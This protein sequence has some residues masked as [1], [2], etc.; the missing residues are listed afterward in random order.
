MPRYNID[1]DSDSRDLQQERA[2]GAESTVRGA[3]QKRSGGYLPVIPKTDKAEPAAHLCAVVEIH[4]PVHPDRRA[5]PGAGEFEEQQ[6]NRGPGHDPHN[7]Q[8]PLRDMR[9]GHH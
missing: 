7:L 9:G 8:D 2:V 6:H 5:V 1:G 3:D 4:V